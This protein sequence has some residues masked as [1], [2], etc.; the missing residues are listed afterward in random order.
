MK[1]GITIF[2][3]SAVF[4][5]ESLSESSQMLGLE[6]EVPY[7][8]YRHAE[9]VL[10][11]VDRH[12][13]I[14]AISNLKRAVDHRIKHITSTY[15]IKKTPVYR[16][17]QSVLEAL[18]ALEVVKPLMLAQL[19]DIRNTVEHHYADPPTLPRCREL[20]EFTWY[21][22]RSTD[23]LAKQ[24]PTD[25][26]LSEVFDG[27]YSVAYLGQPTNDWEQTVSV[28]IPAELGS[29]TKIDNAFAVEVD[30]IWSREEYIKEEAK[31][32]SFL[33]RLAERYVET[34]LLFVG[35]LV[36]SEDNLRFLRL[37]FQAGA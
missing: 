36:D 28:K 37:Y 21:F 35:R 4:D 2:V 14:D 1:T 12:F 11:L 29:H 20:A 31:R 23:T 25:F 16:S 13:L 3:S 5:W 26:G 19:T 27:A 22:L 15:R 17:T 34:D 30:A 8:Y 24:L 32:G 10:E 6:W 7:S 33:K 18:A 9:R